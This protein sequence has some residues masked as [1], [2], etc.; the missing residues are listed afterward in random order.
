M[1]NL[2][3]GPFGSYF[4]LKFLGQGDLAEMYLA[5]HYRSKDQVA[6][7]I[8]HPHLIKTLGHLFLDATRIMARLDHPHIVHILDVDTEASG[9]V[10]QRNEYVYV[11]LSYALHGS[12]RQYHPQ[13]TRVALPTIVQYV[14][15]LASALQYAHAQEIMHLRLKPENILI[16]AHHELL[17]SDFGFSDNRFLTSRASLPSVLYAAPEQILGKP[18]MKSDQYAL[19]AIVYEWLCGA[20]P[21]TGSVK[22]VMAKHLRKKP[23]PLCERVSAIPPFIEEVIMIALAKDPKDRFAS[24][25][26]FATAFEQAAR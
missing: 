21:F 8:L 22:E 5:E 7:K 14:Q 11:A 26:A 3:N 24:I 20:P 23:R 16:G 2:T 25:T 12:A 9:T 4:F 10:E 17:L 1:H 15:Q 18:H 19:G 13:G 6:L